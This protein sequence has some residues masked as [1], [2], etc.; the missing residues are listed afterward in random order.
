MELAQS[1][2]PHL[3]KSKRLSPASHCRNDQL[4][5][6][7]KHED[8]APRPRYTNQNVSALQA[9]FLLPRIWRTAKKH[10][11]FVTRDPCSEHPAGT[12][13]PL[14]APKLG[15]TNKETNCDFDKWRNGTDKKCAELAER[16]N[17][18]VLRTAESQIS[19]ANVNATYVFKVW[20]D[21]SFSCLSCF[22]F[23]RNFLA[24][25]CMVLS[26]GTPEVGHSVSEKGS[27]GSAR[28]RFGAPPAPPCTPPLFS[29]I[30]CHGLGCYHEDVG[31]LI[32][33]YDVKGA[34][35][36]HQNLFRLHCGYQNQ[37]NH[38][39][40]AI[41]SKNDLNHRLI[42]RIPRFFSP[43][44]R[45]VSADVELNWLNACLPIQWNAQTALL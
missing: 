26:T 43:C 1:P 13:N 8:H 37:T 28:M 19:F 34:G 44:K 42:E 12:N 23:F 18:V 24:N 45:A 38:S 16:R 11:W 40:W 9:T 29:F 4:P 35:S 10:V 30:T 32:T 2:T 5:T 3:W 20:T 31:L 17:S 15:E 7:F 14:L 33:L 22:F 27:T 41:S 21:F 25:A 36:E 39:T 6:P